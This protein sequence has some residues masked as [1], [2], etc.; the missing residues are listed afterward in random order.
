[1]GLASDALKAARA[2]EAAAGT[3]VVPA[4][5]SD[6]QQPA[7]FAQ[8]RAQPNLR[9]DDIP[10]P[11]ET[12]ATGPLDQDEVVLLGQCERALEELFTAERVAVRALANIRDRRLYRQ[13]HDS[14]EDYV[15][16]R[17]D[18]GR[19]WAHRL[20]ESL[21]VS[22][23]LFP[24]GNTLIPTTQSR[25]LAPVLRE[26]GPEAV[27]EV[28]EQAASQGPVTGKSL[29]LVR[30]LA[31][32]KDE[33]EIVDAEIVDDDDLT[34]TLKEL[35]GLRGQFAGVSARFE[36]ILPKARLAGPEANSLLSSIARDCR[37]NDALYKKA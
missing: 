8:G 9:L 17:F 15:R 34:E 14:F 10:A 28:H 35:R 25:E 31:R 32:V 26:E 29:R 33:E 37:R 27:R 5:F 4:G 2:A 16:E 6:T 24:M 18:R 7:P 21:Q 22:E 23:V 11:V 36:E 12:E 30:E 3:A 13:S 20:I 1:M 19:L